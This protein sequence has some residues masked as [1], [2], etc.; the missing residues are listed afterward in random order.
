MAENDDV[1]P[2]PPPKQ[3]KVPKDSG[4]PLAIAYIILLTFIGYILKRLYAQYKASKKS[5]S[6]FGGKHPEREAYEEL[7]KRSPDD[8]EALRK[9]LMR[10]A[11]TDV[12]RLMSLSEEKESVYSLMRNGALSE[13]MW[14]SFKLAESEMQ[15]EMSDLQAEAETFKAGWS[16]NIIQEAA[17]LVK[18]EGELLEIKRRKD[19]E[20]KKKRDEEKKALKQKEQEEKQ[21]QQQEERARRLREKF[22]ASEEKNL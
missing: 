14:S 15:L 20:E 9:A 16:N 22:L 5:K 18:R 19:L 21:G 4:W 2:P 3:P 17:M 12:K 6:W 11:M 7:L 13:D 10:R 8:E 1:P